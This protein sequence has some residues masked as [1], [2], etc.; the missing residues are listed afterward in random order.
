MRVLLVHRH[1]SRTELK[2]GTTSLPAG[3]EGNMNSTGAR[4]CDPISLSTNLEPITAHRCQGNMHG[5]RQP[6]H[7][8]RSVKCFLLNMKLR[9]NKIDFHGPPQS[10]KLIENPALNEKWRQRQNTQLVTLLS[11]RF[12]HIWSFSL[13]RTF[14]MTTGSRHCLEFPL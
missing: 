14:L 13:Y 10:G 12:D 3:N 8:L 1:R 2:E 5:A 11:Q 9:Q 7:L 6:A 4:S